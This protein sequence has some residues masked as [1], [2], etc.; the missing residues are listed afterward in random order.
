MTIVG[1]DSSLLLGFY[2]SQLNNSL[3]L[4]TAS[5]NSSASSSTSTAS[6]NNSATAKDVTPWTIKQPDQNARDA[7]V[8]NTTN[9]IDLSKVPVLAGMSPD[10]KTEQ[11]NQKLFALYTAVNNLSYLATMSKRDGVSAGQMAGYNTRFQTGLQQIENFVSTATFNNFTLQ[12]AASSSSATSTATV[13]NATF[14]YTTGSLVSG[15]N[16]SNPVPGLSTTDS[17]TIGVTKAGVTNNVLIDL[18]KVSGALTLDN[19]IIYI[20][21]QLSAAGYST[22]FQK[23]ITSGTIDQLSKA[24]FGLQINN[25]PSESL[26][27]TSASATPALYVSGTSGLTTAT[28]TSPVDNQGRLV[29]LSNLSN[30]TSAFSVNANPSSGT[31]TASSTVVDSNGD[32]Y[33]VGSATGNFGSQY[34]AGSQDAYLTKYDNAGHVLWTRML[35]SAGTASGASLALNPNGGVTIVG[36]TNAALTST[37]VANGNQDSFATQYD[38]NGNQVWT[39]QLQTLNNNQG[40]SVSVDSAGNVYIGGQTNGVIGSGQTKIG[41]SDAY[42]TKLDSKGKVV[43]EQQF[44][45]TANDSVSATALTSSGDLMVASVQNGHAILSKYTGGNATVAPAWQMDLGALNPGGAVTGIAVSGSKVY[46]T[47]TTQNASLNAGSATVVTPNSGGLDAFVFAA[48]DNGTSAT[49]NTVSY[50]GTSGTDKGGG[51][52]VD[53]S[54]TVFVTG[55]TTGTFAGQTRSQA[56]TSN[57]FVASLASNGTTNWIRQYGG[58]DGQSVGTGVAIDPTGSSVLDALGLPSGKLPSFTSSDLLSATTLRPGDSFQMKIDSNYNRTATIT[59]DKGETLQSLVTKLNGQLW[60]AGKASVVYGSGGSGLKIEVQAGVNITLMSGPGNFDALKRLGLTPGLLSNTSSTSTTTS[61]N[62][63][64][65]ASQVFS[66]GLDSKM[67]IATTTGAGTARA[68]LLGVL[69]AIQKAY[70]TTNTP[71]AA[72][73]T[74]GGSANGGTVSAY[75]QSQLANYNLAAAILGGGSSSTYTVG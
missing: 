26:T 61:S 13:P 37:A 29:K 15:A 31:T 57:M 28:S 32:V 4:S 8:L 22:R 45:T 36:T 41:G 47:G 74:A 35:G 56:N 64:K 54:G 72:A 17:F 46:V 49:A 2:Q 52:T 63:N 65:A 10:T 75:T 38:A 34:N 53:S 51:I 21:S 23:V 24:S 55:S 12:A 20:N 50:L 18:S 33:V 30:P 39:T 6:T 58:L 59:I 1:F 71:T 43:Y 66:L 67:S 48:T 19:V 25:A 3:L 16:I 44:G 40:T 42:I 62:T 69:S 60:G 11:D 5:V 73:T 9:W 7:L 14:G 70:R 27:M 68:Q